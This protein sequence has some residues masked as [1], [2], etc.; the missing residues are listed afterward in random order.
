MSRL[1][2]LGVRHVRARCEK[3][4]AHPNCYEG[5]NRHPSSNARRAASRRTVAFIRV[6]LTVDNFPTI[7]PAAPAFGQQR[8]RTSGLVPASAHSASDSGTSARCHVAPV[9]A[10]TRHRYGTPHILPTQTASCRLNRTTWPGS[11]MR[12][13]SRNEKSH[14]D[15]W[16]VG[17]GI[18]L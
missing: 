3:G 5:G 16:P 18:R 12:I 10:I 8:T 14:R 7:T 6:M 4:C 1:G 9:A 2:R 17:V 15:G 13:A 11:R